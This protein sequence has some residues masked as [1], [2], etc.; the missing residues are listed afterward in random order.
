MSPY[1]RYVGIET[2]VVGLNQA[3]SCEAA[4]KS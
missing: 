1:I 3:Q 2:L 4:V